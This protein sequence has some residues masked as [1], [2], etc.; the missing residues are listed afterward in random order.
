MKSYSESY[1]AAGVDVVAGYR[2]VELMKPHIDRT[3]RQGVVGG[4]G[5][6]GGVFEPNLAGYAKPVFISGTDSVGSKLKLAFIAGRHDTVGIDAVAMCVNDIICSGAQPLFFLDYIGIGKL[7]PEVVAEIVK[8]VADGCVMAGCALI[9]GETAELPGLY[10]EGEYDLVGFAV[11]IADKDRLPDPKI[12]KAGD[13]VI[14]LASSGLHSNGFSLVRKVFDIENA[15]IHAL[16]PEFGKSL[17][18]ELLT[19]TRIYA[20][21]IMA[22]LKSG[23]SVLGICNITGGGFFENIPRCLPSGLSAKIDRSCIKTPAV[24]RALQQQ[25]SISER[26]MFNTFNMGVGMVVISAKADADE[27]VS[28]LKKN[29][30]DAAVIGEVVESDEGV[31]LCQGR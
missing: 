3:A 23:L 13:T 9:G 1:K 21:P 26:E 6:F 28:L 5:G 19:P 11:G 20:K 8:G 4:I 18:D 16:I 7:V 12:I 30:E 17:I 31:I 2:A 27:A 14:G 10:A 22:L 15:D 24:F 29:N 25:G